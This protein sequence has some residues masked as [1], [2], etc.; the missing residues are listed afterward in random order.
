MHC[1]QQSSSRMQN[2]CGRATWFLAR[3]QQEQTFRF[4]A[5]RRL[6]Q[7]VLQLHLLP[8]RSRNIPELESICPSPPQS[9]Q[10]R[11]C[12]CCDACCLFFSTESEISET[13]I[14]KLHDRH[15]PVIANC[16][17]LVKEKSDGVTRWSSRKDQ[18]RCKVRVENDKALRTL[19]ACGQTE[20]GSQMSGLYRDQSVFV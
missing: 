20:L 3:Q 15:N 13:N 14:S 2:S 10:T 4:P 8:C 12:C 17:F 7:G 1:C 19:L 9:R 11:C 6:D 16:S 5:C 18:I